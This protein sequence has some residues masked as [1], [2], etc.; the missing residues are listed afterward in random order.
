MA[1]THSTT[2]EALR[3][4]V[5]AGLDLIQ[6]PEVLPTE[7]PDELVELIKERDVLIRK[8]SLV[9]KEGRVVDHESLPAKPVFSTRQC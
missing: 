6:H 4:S 8:L 3:V 9:M 1:E 5:L 2:S 7:I